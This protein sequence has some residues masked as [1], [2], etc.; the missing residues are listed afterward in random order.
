[1][2]NK[3]TGFSFIE[4]VLVLGIAGLIFMMA[5]IAL[6]S[7]WI[8]QRDAQ[9]KS[10]VM[11]FI[12]DLKTYQTNNSRG[13]LP[14]NTNS[15]FT[16]KEARATASSDT[17]SWMAFIRDYVPKSF[18]DPNTNADYSNLRFRIY[19]CSPA[20]VGSTCTN[21]GSINTSTTPNFDKNTQTLYI[22]IGATCDGDHAVKTNGDRS[23][24]VVQVLERCGRYCHST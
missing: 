8:S 5:F 12:S 17:T 16:L 13:A 18:M 4:V 19:T 14:V 21:L 1:M 24:A 6:P 22:V 7:L 3:R 9:R 23:V 2:S 10:N 20:T 15:N 11:S